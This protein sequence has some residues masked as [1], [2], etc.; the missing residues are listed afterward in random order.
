M[1]EPIATVTVPSE[2]ADPAIK[3]ALSLVQKRLRE[4]RAHSY[5]GKVIVLIRDGKP[6]TVQR[7]DAEL[8]ERERANP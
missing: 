5:T 3:Q 8:V 7:E 2:D 1:M 6:I 4:F